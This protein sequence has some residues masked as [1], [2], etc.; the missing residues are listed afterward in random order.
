MTRPFSETP[1][2]E[3][4]K[5]RKN[6]LD[7]RFE[8]CKFSNRLRRV[9]L[10]R[11]VLT[12]I[13]AGPLLNNLSDDKTWRVFMK[14]KSVA[15]LSAGLIA[16]GLSHAALANIVT[17]T[18]GTSAWVGT[19]V[20]QTGAG[21]LTDSG[22]TTSD[23]DSWGGNA[24]GA[25]G[26]GA[27]QET[28]EVTQTGNLGAAEL[29]MAGGAATFNVELYDLGTPPAGYQSA[30]NSGANITQIN[31]LPD[32]PPSTLTQIT[33]SGASGTY[34][35]ATTNLL[36]SGDTA[37]FNGTSNPQALWILSFQGADASISLSPNT[38]YILSLD[39]TANADNTWWERGGVPVTAYNTGEAMN[40]DGVA[41]MQNF[42]NKSSVRDFDTAVV[43]PEP[44]TLGLLAVGAVGLMARRRA[45]KA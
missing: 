13:L 1:Y 16:V 42:E 14:V 38:L 11:I 33:S 40:E 7:R 35:V 15:T 25:N 12:R 17:S 43:V 3:Y 18:S 41:Q 8:R 37:T 36:A 6:F 2:L 5:N 4:D 20:F 31:N 23:N 22:G 9:S 26:F 44:A 19:P 32:S 28:F 30:P 34:N 27:L 29:V 10:A 21:P 45:K 24:N 39:P